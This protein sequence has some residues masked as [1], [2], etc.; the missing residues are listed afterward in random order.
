MGHYEKAVSPL[1]SCL[2]AREALL[3]TE[4]PH[5]GA[6]LEKLAEAYLHRGELGIAASSVARALRLLSDPPQGDHTLRGALARA[7]E[8]SGLLQL[9]L[10]GRGE[11]AAIARATEHFEVALALRREM[12]AAGDNHPAVTRMLQRLS[13]VY[14]MQPERQG[15]AQ[16]TLLE[17]MDIHK[18]GLAAGT[19]TAADV[20]GVLSQMAAIQ[21]EPARG[22]VHLHE[23]LEMLEVAHG[24]RDLRVTGTLMD[25]SKLYDAQG[26]FHVA[27]RLLQRVHR[28]R[29][30]CLEPGHPQLVH[31]KN[32]L[33]TLYSKHSLPLPDELFDTP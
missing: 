3:G 1:L 6:V 27:L 2:T 33:I 25:L 30:A 15:Q 18:R 24:E 20:A 26:D 19:A 8:T 21:P 22:I 5:V 11:R 4:D 10:S 32:R 13:G 29:T 7:W 31:I 17:L 28:I 12:H 9:Q 14:A 16:G 23:A